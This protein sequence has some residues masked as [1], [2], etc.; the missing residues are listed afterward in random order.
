MKK[1]TPLV[2]CA[3]ARCMTDAMIEVEQLTRQITEE[4]VNT[5]L[6]EEAS[7]FSLI[8]DATLQKRDQSRG[9]GTRRL[10]LSGI[11]LPM[12]GNDRVELMS[13]WAILVVSAVLCEMNALGSTPDQAKIEEAI[14]S[15]CKALGAREPDVEKLTKNL[16]WRIFSVCQQAR[17]GDGIGSLKAPRNDSAGVKA[18]SKEVY[19][20]SLLDGNLG[21]NEK[22][23]SISE[24]KGKMKGTDCE[25]IVNEPEHQLFVKG[26][27]KQYEAIT[28][29]PP[30][31]RGLLWLVLANVGDYVT[32]AE[33]KKVFEDRATAGPNIY[34]Y[35]FYLG[36]LLRINLRDRVMKK[37]HSK[38]YLIP[39][40]G[41]SFCWLR[42][43]RDPAKSELLY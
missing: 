22:F 4:F 31:Q 16:G 20:D 36:K 42:Q 9:I 18:H 10:D 1:L 26:R 15:S 24:A 11:G 30:M 37:G 25:I 38:R 40:V 21:R 2:L 17:L 43:L 35:R 28:E 8:W 39:K 23:T 12:A 41:W 3:S 27:K 13:P 5:E 14:K 29:I 6:P 33:I 19:M 34:L 7:Y 32:H